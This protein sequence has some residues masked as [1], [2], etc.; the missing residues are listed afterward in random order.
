MSVY[1]TEDEALF[2]LEAEEQEA[3][4][5]P[6]GEDVPQDEDDD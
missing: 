3:L 5:S 4:P 2:A 6:Y 1:A